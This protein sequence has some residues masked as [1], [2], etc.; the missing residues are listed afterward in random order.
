LTTRTISSPRRRVQFPRW[1]P[2]GAESQITLAIDDSITMN[3]I[4]DSLDRAFDRITDFEAVQSGRSADEL[5]AAVTRL[6]ES[7]GILDESRSLIAERVA[8]IKGAPRARGHVLLGLIVGLMA[9]ELDAEA[10]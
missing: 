1:V 8:E 4:A 6:Q 7:V 10:R 9:A 3:E 5:V 2:D